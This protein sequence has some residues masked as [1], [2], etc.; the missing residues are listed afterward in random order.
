VAVFALQYG[1]ELLQS[2]R[3]DAAGRPNIDDMTL[4]PA[5]TLSPLFI[6]CMITGAAMKG[7]VAPASL[8]GLALLTFYKTCADV[9][10]YCVERDRQRR[11]RDAYIS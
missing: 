2:M 8:L 3:A 11:D 7:G 6:V 9:S 10:V 1:W 4:L 5:A